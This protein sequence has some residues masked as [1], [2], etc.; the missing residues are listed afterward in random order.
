MICKYI[1]VQFPFQS[2]FMP[3]KLIKIRRPSVSLKKAHCC[4]IIRIPL[5]IRREIRSFTKDVPNNL[6][7]SFLSNSDLTTIVRRSPLLQYA[8]LRF[9]KFTY[10]Q[11]SLQTFSEDSSWCLRCLRSGTGYLV[12]G[13]VFSTLEFPLDVDQ[14]TER[15]S[16]YLTAMLQTSKR[17]LRHRDTCLF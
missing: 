6:K 13:K 3:D 7:Y 17:Q 11:R 1:D 4:K 2:I 16:L 14:P 10:L 8:N 15:C 9:V 5:L 12:C